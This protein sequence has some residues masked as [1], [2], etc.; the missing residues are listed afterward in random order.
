MQIIPTFI[1]PILKSMCAV[2]VCLLI[3]L[4]RI[5]LDQGNV[6]SI[7]FIYTYAK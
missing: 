7:P 4:T 6:I 5:N 1:T 2:Y 3:I